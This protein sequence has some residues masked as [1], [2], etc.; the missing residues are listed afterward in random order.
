LTLIDCNIRSHTWVAFYG[1]A[2]YC[3]ASAIDFN[4]CNLTG[5]I[6]QDRGGAIYLTNTEGVLRGCQ[7]DSN[8][9][10]QGGAICFI[11]SDSVTLMD[12]GFFHDTTDSDAGA[13]YCQYSSPTFRRCS[14]EDNVGG[15]GASVSA[16]FASTPVFENCLFLRNTGY[17]CAGI[18]LYSNCSTKITN[19]A[20]YG[21]SGSGGSAV[22]IGSECDVILEN[23]IIASGL[24][25]A[26]ISCADATANAILSCCDIFG[27]AGGDWVG[28]IAD[29]LGIRGNISVN[30]N[31]RNITQGDF[32]LKSTACGDSFDS[33]CIDTGS[34][35]IVD[36]L[37][38]CA[39][40]LG[41]ILSDMGAYGGGDS[42]AVAIDDLIE[43]L[44]ARFAL[45]QN[46][47]N[48]FNSQTAISFVLPET[49][50][51][52]IQ[53]YDIMG[54]QIET[55]LNEYRESG[56]HEIIWDAGDLSTGIY[57][58]TIQTD[59]YVRTN[60]MILLR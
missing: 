54:R 23:T 35:A 44:P 46:F 2:I 21:N 8:A 13:I 15:F 27:N 22:A 49:S 16:E 10:V 9:A 52:K 25:G 26:G 38:D 24:G 3:E 11:N 34:P 14:F 5:N 20:F 31:F 30:P 60:K 50:K 41:I 53:I 40:G 12:C 37:L 17:S 58:Y 59:N 28:C 55:C 1:G 33:P 45:L 7:F 57:F 32:R 39:W 29:Q 47:P 36:S 42:A 56:T 51:V 6:A 4:N 43:R 48:P 18:G 19:C